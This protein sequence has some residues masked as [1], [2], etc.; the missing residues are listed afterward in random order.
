MHVQ[1]P[2]NQK[3]P[4]PT[5]SGE[6]LP[7][8]KRATVAAALLLVQNSLT[9][10]ML[11]YAVLLTEAPS[12]HSPPKKKNSIPP[13]ALAERPFFIYRNMAEAVTRT[14]LSL[15]QDREGGTRHSVLALRTADAHRTSTHDTLTHTLLCRTSLCNIV[16]PC[17]MRTSPAVLTGTPSS[18]R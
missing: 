1:A 4:L 17:S 18:Q 15:C 6:A 12:L 13:A 9:R 2:S 5:P 3:H 10:S 16:R 14:H 7:S 8:R 11:L